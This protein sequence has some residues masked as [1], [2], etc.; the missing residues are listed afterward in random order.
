MFLD[1]VVVPTPPRSELHSK[2]FFDASVPLSKPG[3]IAYKNRRIEFIIFFI[4]YISKI[5][6][7]NSTN[8]DRVNLTIIFSLDSLFQI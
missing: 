6:L 5:Y 8:L 2:E 3:R 1:N 4:H 7:P